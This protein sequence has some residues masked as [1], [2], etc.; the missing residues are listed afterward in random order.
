MAAAA[1][2]QDVG[3]NFAV[4][5]GDYVGGG[6]GDGD[7]DGDGVGD[8]GIVSVGI[9][10]AVLY[11][12]SDGGYSVSQYS[13]SRKERTRTGAAEREPSVRC[14]QTDRWKYRRPADQQSTVYPIARQPN[15]IRRRGEPESV[16]S[17]DSSGNAGTVVWSSLV[18]YAGIM[19]WPSLVWSS[20]P[21]TGLR[22]LLASP[23]GLQHHELVFTRH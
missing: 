4:C 5:Y 7:G 23:P 20:A 3:C 17:L 19:I 12:N 6:D 22:S 8:G 2:F 18:R 15:S 16:S 1:G 11:C 10:D 14:N 9:W 13:T 21:L